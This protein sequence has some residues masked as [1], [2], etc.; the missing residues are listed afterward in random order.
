MA[1]TDAD[2]VEQTLRATLCDVLGLDPE[3]VD[4]FTDA[5]PLFGALP[6]F[7]SMA[8]AELVPDLVHPLRQLAVAADQ[9]AG[10]QGRHLLVRGGQQGRAPTAVPQGE[11]QA[12]RV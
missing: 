2:E 4:G 3:R 8:V 7:D 6:E 1:Y 12:S 11:D 9:V 5:T 10:E